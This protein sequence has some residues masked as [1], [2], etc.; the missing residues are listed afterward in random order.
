VPP[1][2]TRS[3]VEIVSIGQDLAMIGY[4]LW[5]AT[6]GPM[7]LPMLIAV[8]VLV[9]VVMLKEQLKRLPLWQRFARWC[10]PFLKD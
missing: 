2:K 5:A 3:A 10:G 7:R 4:N 8:C 6:A 1:A 9:P